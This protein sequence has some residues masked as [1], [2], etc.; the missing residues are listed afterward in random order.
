V[1]TAY[2]VLLHGTGGQT[3]GKRLVGVRV[4]HV[5]GEPIG[6]ARALGRTLGSVLSAFPLGLGYLAVAWQC[7]KRGFHDLLAGTR[8]VRARRG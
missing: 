5:S 4:V 7:D 6:Y 3:L 2:F 8:V 1:P